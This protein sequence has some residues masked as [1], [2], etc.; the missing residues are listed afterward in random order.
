MQPRGAAERQPRGSREAQ[1]ALPRLRRPVPPLDRRRGLFAP[2]MLK[3]ERWSVFHTRVEA[4]WDVREGAVLVGASTTAA[5]CRAPT[6]ARTAAL[7]VA[8]LPVA[9]SCGICVSCV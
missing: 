4:P 8:R 9:V 6:H 7:G 1:L 5:R 2:A 3:C